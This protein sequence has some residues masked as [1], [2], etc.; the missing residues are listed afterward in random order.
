M[1]IAEQAKNILEGKTC[2]WCK[3]NPS[4]P[5]ANNDLCLTWPEGDGNGREE[6]VAKP[7]DVQT[8]KRWKYGF[9]YLKYVYMKDFISLEKENGDRK[10]CF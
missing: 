9:F 8:C 1:T 3:Y 10:G 6:M 4:R 2:D 7:G 5:S